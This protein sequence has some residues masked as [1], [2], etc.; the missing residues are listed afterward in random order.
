L[1]RNGAKSRGDIV[2]SLLGETSGGDGEYPILQQGGCD[3]VEAFGTE[4]RED[5][6]A[7]MSEAAVDVATTDGGALFRASGKSA[8]CVKAQRIL[9]V[10][11]PFVPMPFCSPGREG[12][13]LRSGEAA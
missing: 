1:C 6:V 9:T 5:M 7:K 2:D 8:P 10:T 12:R 4:A 13:D 3:L 11:W